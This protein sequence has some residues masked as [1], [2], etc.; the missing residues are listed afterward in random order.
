MRRFVPAVVL[1]FAACSH[2]REQAESRRVL[3]Q[4]GMPAD[5]VVR[6][7]GPPGHKLKVATASGAADQTT[8][9]WTFE[10]EGPPSV[11]DFME[12]VLAAGALVLVVAT[13]SSGG[14]GIRGGDFPRHRFRVGFGP[15]GRVRAVTDLEALE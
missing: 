15:D 2:A 11:G 1:A 10:I 13:R 14:G 8:E 3:V 6:R 12:V 5:E 7:I 9:V 4:P